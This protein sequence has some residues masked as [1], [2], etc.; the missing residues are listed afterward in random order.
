MDLNPP[1]ESKLTN[2]NGRWNINNLFGI[3]H[4]ATDWQSGVIHSQSGYV[5]LEVTS[6]AGIRCGLQRQTRHTTAVSLWWWWDVSSNTRLEDAL[7]VERRGRDFG[8]YVL[9]NITVRSNI[10]NA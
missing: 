7:V 5:E 8:G 6:V 9:L 3:P 2:Q 4:V 10:Q 1:G